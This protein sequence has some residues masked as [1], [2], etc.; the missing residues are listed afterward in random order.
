MRQAPHTVQE[1]TKT[2][3]DTQIQYKYTNIILKENKN[4]TPSYN[5]LRRTRQK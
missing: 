2:Q 3:E 4:T 1:K 5:T